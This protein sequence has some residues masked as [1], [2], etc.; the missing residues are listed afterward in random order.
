MAAEDPVVWISHRGDARCGGCG[1]EIPAGAYLTLVRERGPR[2][3]RCSGFGEL[4]FVPSGDAALTRRAFAASKL[5]A[6]VVRFSKARK[7]NER[8]GVLVEPAALA[9][10]E[11]SCAADAER[12]DGKREVGRARATRTDDAFRA[13]FAEAIRQ[14]FPDCPPAEA[15]AIAAHACEKGSGRVGRIAAAT[16]LDPE[17]VFLAV[18]A[19]VRHAL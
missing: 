16:A 19:R 3:V 5:R 6:V 1:A 7:R 17:A 18:Q 4:V 11:T 13:R 12:R 15:A 8:Q 10:A 2:C 9:A 14:Q